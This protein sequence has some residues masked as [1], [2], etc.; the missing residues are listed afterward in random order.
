MAPYCENNEVEYY[1]KK[2]WCVGSLAKK[3]I[4]KQS[5]KIFGTWSELRKAFWERIEQQFGVKNTYDKKCTKEMA[6]KID[7]LWEEYIRLK[8][9]YEKD[10]FD[11]HTQK[12]FPN[13]ICS[14]CNG[15]G[16]YESTYN[17]KSKWDW[18]VIGGRWNGQVQASPRN[19]GEGGFNFGDEF[20]QI[21]EN[22]T[23]VEDYII[24]IEKEIAYSPYSIITPNGEWFEKGEMGW[25]GIVSNEN[26]DWEK[27]S[28][29]IL[30][31][32]KENHV[33]V[34]VDVHI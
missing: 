6:K 12:T 29:E 9:N 13:P 3:Q 21:Y 5:D 17:Q 19:D 23:T 34:G 28:M 27:V 11:K 15:K 31:K 25:W 22:I 20:H 7:R 30:K 1:Q 14:D 8:K 26:T 10:Q 16:F 18:Y 32:Y 33:I 24:Q 4:E 2:C